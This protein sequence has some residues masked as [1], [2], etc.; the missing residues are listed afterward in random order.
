MIYV[1]L[2]GSESF[3]TLILRWHTYRLSSKAVCKETVVMIRKNSPFY[4]TSATRSVV[5][6]VVFVASGCASNPKGSATL[7]T[8]TAEQVCEQR[9]DDDRHNRYQYY[10]G[11]LSV[12]LFG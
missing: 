12:A 5:L 4:K 9:C 3:L 6:A 7:A 10:L 2:L 8:E 11:I 1:V